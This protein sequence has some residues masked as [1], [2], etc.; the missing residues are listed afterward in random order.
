MRFKKLF[1]EIIQHVSFAELQ[2]LCLARC[3]DFVADLPP[4]LLQSIGFGMNEVTGIQYDSVGLAMFGIVQSHNG[5]LQGALLQNA[6]P[7]I[8]F[9]S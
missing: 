3:L 5:S 6:S 7:T 1:L 8:S 9:K 4:Q 2:R